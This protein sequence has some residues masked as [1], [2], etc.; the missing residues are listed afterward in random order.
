MRIWNSDSLLCYSNLYTMTMIGRFIKHFL[1]FIHLLFILLHQLINLILFHWSIKIMRLLHHWW[2][3]EWLL[4]LFLIFMNI[5]VSPHIKSIWSW[6]IIH[7]VRLAT[8]LL[9]QSTTHSIYKYII[10]LLIILTIYNQNH[11]AY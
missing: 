2:T 6:F 8:S 7:I 10:S 5:I 1:K 9:R 4:W 11:N 3:K